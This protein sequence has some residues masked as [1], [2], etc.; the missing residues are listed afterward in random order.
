MSCN[1]RDGLHLFDAKLGTELSLLRGLSFRVAL[2][3]VLIERM[4]GKAGHTSSRRFRAAVKSTPLSSALFSA[5]KRCV[6]Y[7]A[8]STAFC[9]ALTM[10]SVMCN[11]RQKR[12]RPSRVSSAMVE[13]VAESLSSNVGTSL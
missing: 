4:R 1:D 13:L 11:G 9:L 12:K 8:S 3:N 7:S 2:A 10:S 5:R 6:R